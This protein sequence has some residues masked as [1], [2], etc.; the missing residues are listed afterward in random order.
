MLKGFIVSRKKKKR[1]IKELRKLLKQKEKKLNELLE[2]QEDPEEIKKLASEIVLI[3]QEITSRNR[4]NIPSLPI[5]TDPHL[6]EIDEKYAKKVGLVSIT[7]D[8]KCPKCGAPF[9]GNTLNGKPWCF[10]CN[11]E[12]TKGGKPPP[13]ISK[14]KYPKNV[15]FKPL[16]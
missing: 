13:K 12:L 16:D 1:K 14:D 8:L 15:T 5:I 3:N 10:K 11:M 6:R 9:R 7:P 2:N 4:R